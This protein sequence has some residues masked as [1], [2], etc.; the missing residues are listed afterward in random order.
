MNV[1]TMH[2]KSVCGS[3]FV[4][5][6][7]DDARIDPG[8]A[9][10]LVVKVSPYVADGEYGLVEMAEQQ[11]NIWFHR[12]SQYSL[13]QFSEDLASK[14]IWGPSQTLA[15][16]VLDQYT[17][18][19]WKLRRDEHMQQMIKDRWDE[20][21]A[22]LVVDVVS[23]D[24][25]KGKSSSDASKGRCVSGVTNGTNAEATD[26]EGC[27]DTHSSPQAAP[28]QQPPA[29]DWSTL[30]I[31]E[32]PDDDGIAAQLVDEDLVFEAMGFKVA[33]EPEEAG[34]GQDVPFPAM[35]AEMQEDINEAAV[36]V[37]DTADE[38]P[39]YEWDRDHPD[40]SVGICYPSMPELRLA[41]KQH[42][43]VHEFEL[44]T[45][46]SDKERYR[47]CCAARGC[48]W[49]LR[50]RTQHDGSVRV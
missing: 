25:I 8:S 5:I 2:S 41:A 9:F 40:L 36:N 49:K 38:E 46:H 15:V 32:N 19:E 23:K 22:I 44:Q 10:R 4:V 11:H 18:S 16:W 50:A 24:S 17:G 47:V 14:I 43:I 37:D 1:C 30:T 33:V 31:L 27:G 48:P 45:E 7:Y 12:N 35:S 6:I 34:H 3:S 29:I 20:R 26:V 13:A 39:L 42:A 28:A 21:Q